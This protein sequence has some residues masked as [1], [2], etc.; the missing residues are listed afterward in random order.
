MRVSEIF[1]SLQGECDRVGQPMVF[2]RLWGCN[3]RCK[4]CDTKYAVEGE[5]REMEIGEIVNSIITMGLDK[6]YITGGEPLLHKD[7]ERLIKHLKDRGFEVYLDTNGSLYNDRIFDL[8]D[9]IYMDVK[10]P[11]SG[12]RS[13]DMVICKTL[14]DFNY[15]TIFKFVCSDEGDLQW[16]KKYVGRL[17]MFNPKPFVYLIPCWTKKLDLNFCKTMWNFCTKNNLCMS[18]QQHKIVWGL[19]KGR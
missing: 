11:S 10:T 1:P 7:L 16:V 19:E 6:V 15:K 17:E 18:I 12:E 4:Y 14:S 2:L 8:V 13:D 3:M 9:G 5:F